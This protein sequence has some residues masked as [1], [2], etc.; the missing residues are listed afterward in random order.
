LI[1]PKWPWK[2]RPKGKDFDEHQ[3]IC[4]FDFDICYAEMIRRGNPRGFDICRKWLLQ[5][6]GSWP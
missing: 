3:R 5:C 4:Q 2:D 1:P 6:L